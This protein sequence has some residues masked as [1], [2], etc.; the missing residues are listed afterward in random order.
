MKLRPALLVMAMI[1]VIAG[2]SHPP[3]INVTGTWEGTITGPGGQL[4]YRLVL[5]DNNGT[6]SGNAY[7][8][9]PDYGMWRDS[10]PVTGVRKGE[11]ANMMVIFPDG[12]G[13]F[14]IAG[15]FQGDSFS[16]TA[17]LY[18]KRNSLIGTYNIALT[19]K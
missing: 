13:R 5:T 8:L 12:S 11:Q 15:T 10:G 6:L 17:S 4:G 14:E 18:D 9:D 3:S 2:C 16:G 7:F 1:M 19:R